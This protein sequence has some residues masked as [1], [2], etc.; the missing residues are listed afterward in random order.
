MCFIIDEKRPYKLTAKRDITCYK[1]LN[2]DY[3]SIVKYFQYE[4]GKIHKGCIGKPEESSKGSIKTIDIGFH[5]FSNKRTARLTIRD[6]LRNKFYR[7]IVKCI[8]PKG[9]EYY[10]NS[11]FKEYVSNKIIIKGIL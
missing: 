7:V 5:S 9:S 4:P 1:V 10:Y 3:T 2:K 6:Y 8:I 11:N